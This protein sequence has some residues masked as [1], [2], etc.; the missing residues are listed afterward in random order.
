MTGLKT[1]IAEAKQAAQDYSE[2]K[3]TK[4]LEQPMR[5][6]SYIDPN[7]ALELWHKEVKN[8]DCH[9][10]YIPNRTGKIKGMMRN[11][12]RELFLEGM[13]EEQIRA[14]IKKYVRRW[15]VIPDRDRQVQRVSKDGH[16]YRTRIGGTPNFDIF[17]ANRAEIAPLLE[18]ASDPDVPDAADMN[19]QNQEYIKKL[20]Y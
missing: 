1:K 8:A 13:T 16:P 17:F 4:K 19:D 5:K 6:G 10:G 18:R 20:F 2:K 15:A 9:P 14:L 12:L 7:P 3:A 11:W